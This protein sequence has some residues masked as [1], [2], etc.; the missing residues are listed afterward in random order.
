MAKQKESSANGDINKSEAIREMMAVHPK[1]KSKAIVGFLEDKGIIVRPQLVYFVRSRMKHQK[2][3]QRRQRVTAAAQEMG[4]L[5]PIQL[6]VTV[7][8]LAREAGGFKN[9]KK[10]VDALAE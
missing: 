7:K 8:E 5:S 4:I 2:Q 3:R 10:L 9:L 1:A 6:V